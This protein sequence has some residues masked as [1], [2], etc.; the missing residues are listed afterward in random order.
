LRESGYCGGAPRNALET[1][2]ETI[3]KLPQNAS[4]YAGTGRTALSAQID[5]N[6]EAVP[7]GRGTGL[8]RNSA[9]RPIPAFE[10]GQRAARSSA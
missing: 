10:G 8:R 6:E 5:T 9:E 2:A 1:L 4:V 7:L 3:R